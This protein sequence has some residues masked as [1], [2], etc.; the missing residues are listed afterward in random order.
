MKILLDTQVFLWFIMGSERLSEAHRV[1]IEEGDNQCCISIASLWEIAIKVSLSKL[2]LSFSFDSLVEEHIERN[3]LSLLPLETSHL[4]QLLALPHHH[5]DPFDRM[6]IAQA[7]AED[8]SVISSDP[9]FQK[10][11]LNLI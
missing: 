6:I 2:E 1:L 3:G 10:Y 8:L 11:D 9:L 7:I 4:K 5:R